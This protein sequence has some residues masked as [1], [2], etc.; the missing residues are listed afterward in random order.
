[1]DG[2]L[3]LAHGSKRQE[4]ERILDSI[5]N[6][7]IDRTGE[8]LIFP[9]YLQFSDQDMETGIKYLVD[10]GATTIKVVPL[11]IFDGV[12]VTKDIP[13]ELERIRED[14]PD[15]EIKIS[16]YIGDDDR[17]ADIVADRI[18]SLS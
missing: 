11:F 2:V 14:Y 16:H 8:K 3:L 7:V 13:D 6:K 15:I 9:A 10:K 17:L 1:M 5:V 4:T 12:H 18:N